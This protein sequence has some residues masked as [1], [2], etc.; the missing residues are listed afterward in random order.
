MAILERSLHTPT[1]APSVMNYAIALKVL[2]FVLAL[3]CIGLVAIVTH[4]AP[5]YSAG[6][7]APRAVR[8]RVPAAHWPE[9]LL[10][11]GLVGMLVS[12]VVLAFTCTLIA[13]E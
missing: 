4:H 10:R 2:A 9:F 13:S 12:F 11:G 7:P 1:S 6:S 8:A 3:V 5:A